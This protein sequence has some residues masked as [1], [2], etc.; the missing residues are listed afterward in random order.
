MKK[1]SALFEDTTMA[2]NRWTQGIASREIKANKTSLGDLLNPQ[3]DKPMGAPTTKDVPLHPCLAKSPE[4]VGSMLMDLSNLQAK[5]KTALASNMAQD[6]KKKS[7]LNQLLAISNHN[8][9]M[10]KR[11]VHIFNRLT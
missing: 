8:E 7:D 3:K 5:L 2:Y 4:I 1:A 6:P 11:M 9:K 10:V